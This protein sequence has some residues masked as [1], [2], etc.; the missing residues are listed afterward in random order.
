MYKFGFRRFALGYGSAVAGILFLLSF[1]F[2]ILY[3]RYVMR[4]D[5]ASAIAGG[6]LMAANVEVRRKNHQ[7]PRQTQIA[8]ATAGSAQVKRREKRRNETFP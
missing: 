4:R 1:G 6:D 3:Q 2:S 7:G 5:Y 8:A